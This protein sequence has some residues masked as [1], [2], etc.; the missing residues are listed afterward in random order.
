M[1]IFKPV[2]TLASALLTALSLGLVF[3][4]A[5]DGRADSL[6]LSVDIHHSH[7]HALRV[8][9]WTD[10][11]GYQK[12]G[13]AV[14]FSHDN[15]GS[16]IVGT[17]RTIELKLSEAYAQGELRVDISAPDML[18]L[19]GAATHKFDMQ[20]QDSHSIS[21]N[22]QSRAVGQHYINIFTTANLP[23]GQQSAR[24]FAVSIDSIASNRLGKELE[25]SKQNEAVSQEGA[26][27]ERGM[28]IMPA[29]ESIY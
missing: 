18:I 17:A 21:V 12:P 28:I 13:A 8:A 16:H 5:T 23:N 24:S 7:K 20:D 22:V 26:T 10:E 29:Q 6:A 19:T 15:R 1:L 14:R 11:T 2:F 4:S 25:F 9:G 27:L 3:G